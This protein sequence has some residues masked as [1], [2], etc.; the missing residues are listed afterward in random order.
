MLGVKT[1]LN[2]KIRSSPIFP[3]PMLSMHNN[4][5]LQAKIV[6][7]LFETIR[8]IMFK[9]VMNLHR[10]TYI[11][12]VIDSVIFKLAMT[13]FKSKTNQKRTRQGENIATKTKMTRKRI[14]P[15]S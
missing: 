5:Y 13:I 8:I 12:Q 4:L 6:I 14:G 11:Y 3:P 7:K 10:S 15:F 1:Q 2:W 9:V